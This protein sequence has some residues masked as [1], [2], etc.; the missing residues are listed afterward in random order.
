[1]K[2]ILIIAIYDLWNMDEEAPAYYKRTRVLRTE[3]EALV[4]F[5]RCADSPLVPKC[6]IV[7]YFRD[8]NGEIIADKSL[9]F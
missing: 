6:R 1:M 7:R 4:F 3:A 5:T 2:A 8:S 9:S